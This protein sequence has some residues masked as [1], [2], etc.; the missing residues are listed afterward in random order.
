MSEI[1]RF[2]GLRNH[3]NRFIPSLSGLSEM[4]RRGQRLTACLALGGA[5]ALALLTV[6]APVAPKATEVPRTVPEADVSLAAHYQAA[7]GRSEA[8]ACNSL[9]VLYRSGYEVPQDAFTAVAFFTAACGEGYAE[10]CSN[11]GAM[12]E[13]GS[14][15]ARDLE[16]ARGAYE[17]ACLAG[18]GLGCSNLGAVY[19]FGRGVAVDV[20]RARAL[21]EQACA[22][23]SEVGCSNLE[24]GLEES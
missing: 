8:A 1:L 17:R 10:A 19:Y 11:L 13:N 7:C 5:A 18:S 3:P 16:A 23:G 24:R 12:H 15:V 2:P 14:G 21:F 4:A 22:L 9:G 6:R 20:P